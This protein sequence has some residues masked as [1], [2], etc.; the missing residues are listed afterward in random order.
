MLCFAFL[1][2]PPPLPVAAVVCIYA[3][4]GSLS[5]SVYI[6]ACRFIGESF[7]IPRVLPIST[8][9]VVLALSLPLGLFCAHPR[10]CR[11]F[12]LARVAVRIVVAF[13]TCGGVRGYAQTLSVVRVR[14]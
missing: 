9:S 7:S 11:C 4:C 13:I 2:V 10:R 12:F 6:N 5:L 14:E 8:L 1:D 3:R